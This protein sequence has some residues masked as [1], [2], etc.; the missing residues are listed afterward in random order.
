MK[1]LQ[2]VA[3]GL[4]GWAGFVVAKGV[5]LGFLADIGGLVKRDAIEG[6]CGI[7]NF[8]GVFSSLSISF[9]D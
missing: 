6:E 4:A 8:G 2:V 5:E 7:G 9:P 1:L 3:F